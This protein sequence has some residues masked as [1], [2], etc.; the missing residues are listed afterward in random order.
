MAVSVSVAGVGAFGAAFAIAGA[1]QGVGLRA[2]SVWMNVASNSRSTSGW[3]VVSRSAST[4]GRS[5]LWAAVIAC[6]PSLLE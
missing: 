1:A 5:I 2:I 3:V 6:V 4:V